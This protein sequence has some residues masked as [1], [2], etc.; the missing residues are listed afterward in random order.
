MFFGALTGIV[1]A[2]LDRGDPTPWMGMLERVSMGAWF[3]WLA[4]LATLLLRRLR[5][6]LGRG[7]E[8]GAEGLEPPTAGL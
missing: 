4:V 2:N 7:C 5:Y 3:L 1:S 8:V 6:V